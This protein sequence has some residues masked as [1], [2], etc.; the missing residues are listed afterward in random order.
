[1]RTRKR[2]G[3][4]F[5]QAA[6]VGKVVDIINPQP[7]D[8]FLE[9]GPGIGALTRAL[10]PKAARIIGV[11]IDRDLADELTEGAPPHVRI[12]ADNFLD[13]DLA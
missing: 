1:M 7:T 8:T 6:W 4:H 2:F 3:Q 13:I 9:I 11:E 12:V 5:I 10:A